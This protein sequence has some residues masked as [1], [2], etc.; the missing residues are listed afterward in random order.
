[1][2]TVTKG[3]EEG[4]GGRQIE[5][6]VRQAARVAG[7]SVKQVRRWIA[8]GEVRATKRQAKHGPTWFV[9]AATL[10]PRRASVDTPRA[11]SGE[12]SPL[13]GQGSGDG[14][15]MGSEQGSANVAASLL[16]LVGE[17]DRVL[18]QRRR[19]LEAAVGRIGYLEGEA[20]QTKAIAARAESLAQDQ[21]G[22]IEEAREEIGDLRARVKLRTWAMVVA[23]AGFFVAVGVVVWR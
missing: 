11:R 12:G 17:K 1:M 6:T 9:E 21:A 19:E 7:V 4:G 2:S 5:L 13:D 8:A 14:R 18:E 20:E 22:E 3:V 10:P 15:G 23:F 16:A